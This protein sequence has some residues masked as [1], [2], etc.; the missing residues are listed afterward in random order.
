MQKQRMMATFQHPQHR[1][2]SDPELVL[3]LLLRESE[4]LDEADQEDDGLDTT[5]VKRKEDEKV[6]IQNKT[7]SL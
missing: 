6:I 3:S 4:L 7:P 2:I 1:S 5:V